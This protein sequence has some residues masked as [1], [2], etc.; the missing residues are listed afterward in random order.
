MQRS[1]KE[2]RTCMDSSCFLLYFFLLDTRTAYAG[3]KIYLFSEMAAISVINRALKF[4]HLS[5]VESKY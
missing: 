5:F 2:F 3:H 1:L 4:L